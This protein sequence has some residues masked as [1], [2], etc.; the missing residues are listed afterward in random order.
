MGVSVGNRGRGVLV[1]GGRGVGVSVGIG[2]SVGGGG[3]G[4]SVGRGVA[5]AGGVMVGNGV[6]V[7]VTVGVAVPVG[8]GDGVNVGNMAWPR[9]VGVAV[10]KPFHQLSKMFIKLLRGVGVAIIRREEMGKWGLTITLGVTI[11]G[12]LSWI[13]VWPRSGGP[14]SNKLTASP[15]LAVGEGLG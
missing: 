14:S 11:S 6:A 2:V 3:R 15:C 8:V 7:K 12:I 9:G 5:V 10:L 1:G 13:C 4:V